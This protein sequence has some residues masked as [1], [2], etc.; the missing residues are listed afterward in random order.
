MHSADPVSKS[1]KS[2][3]DMALT[4]L[5][6]PSVPRDEIESV[7]RVMTDYL[8]LSEGRPKHG[9]GPWLSLNGIEEGGPAISFSNLSL[10]ELE[11][12]LTVVLDGLWNRIN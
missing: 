7:L 11:G 5:L 6:L 8:W 2:V 10:E 1:P 4:P 3:S 12:L 9:S